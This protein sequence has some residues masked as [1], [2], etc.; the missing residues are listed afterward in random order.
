MT[1]SEVRDEVRRAIDVLGAPFG[2]RYVLCL[3][4]I[5]MPEIPMANLVALFEACHD[6]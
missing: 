2:N 3:S 5:M 4:N 1:P 6:Q